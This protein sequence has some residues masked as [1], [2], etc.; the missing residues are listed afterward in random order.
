MEEIYETNLDVSYNITSKL[1]ITS[2]ITQLLKNEEFN[3][4]ILI[5][6]LIYNISSKEIFE[7]VLSE[8]DSTDYDNCR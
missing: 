6:Q 8:V 7:K 2:D 3:D 1:N 5:N 4:E